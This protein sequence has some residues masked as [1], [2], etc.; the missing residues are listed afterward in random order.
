VFTR[1]YPPA[2]LAGGPARSVHAL[3]ETLHEDFAFAVITPAFDGSARQTMESVEPGRWSTSG[4][5]RIWY[6]ASRRIAPRTVATLIRQSRP[7]VIYLNSFFDY[8]FTV[9]PLLAARVTARRAR[10]LLAPR[11]EL[12]PG[13][14]ALKRRKKR[15][16]ISVFK[17]LRLHRSVSWHAST[18]QEKAEIDTEF[19]TDL[20]VHVALNLRTGLFGDETVR[21]Q[22]QDA[23]SRHSRSVVFFSRITPKKN[24]L[25]V[26][27]ALSFVENDTHLSIAGPVDDTAY[28]KKCLEAVN[29]MREP[30]LVRYTGPV[31]AQD[32]VPFLRRFDLFVLPT[33]GE[34]F[35]HAVLESLAAGTPVIVGRDTPWQQIE[36]SG[37]GWLCDPADPLA[38]AG[39]IDRFFS[40]D[41]RAREGMRASAHDLARALL[42]DRG[43][44]DANRSMLHAVTS[45]PE[46]RA[47]LGAWSCT[48]AGH[49]SLAAASGAYRSGLNLARAHSAACRPIWAS[50]DGSRSN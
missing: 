46:P 31:L 15:V 13:A 4:Q 24:L 23:R 9:L 3:V 12:S 44:A 42:S 11:G 41:E 1:S 37:A 47:D 10:I 32:V 43:S 30:G 26:I 16:F 48:H 6:E 17:L 45:R 8:R 7:Q 20:N 34:N 33:F 28:W 40:L 25:A 14:L 39:M 21:P 29:E 36:D 2:Y 19:G 49:S 22:S 50:W 27:R 38:L 5:V 35:G 18:D